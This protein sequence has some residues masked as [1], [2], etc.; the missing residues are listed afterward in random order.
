MYTINVPH[1]SGGYFFSGRIHVPVAASKGGRYGPTLAKRLLL[2]TYKW[3][4]T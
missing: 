3:V 1:P 4:C 2:A